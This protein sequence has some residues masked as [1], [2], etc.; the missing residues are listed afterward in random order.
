MTEC[1]GGDD[2]IVQEH[3]GLCGQ[4][5]PDGRYWSHSDTVYM[6]MSLWKSVSRSLAVWNWY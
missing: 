5:E 2:I 1:R 6:I 3:R 4:I